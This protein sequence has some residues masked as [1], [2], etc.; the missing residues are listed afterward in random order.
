MKYL[1]EISDFAK[2]EIEENYTWWIANRSREQAD[3]WIVDIHRRISTI[4][5]DP[6]RYPVIRES[7]CFPFELREMLFSIGRRPT[8]RVVFRINGMVVE[9]F[10]VKHV[11]QEL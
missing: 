4:G 10:H 7:V 6:L 1:V 2:A 3:R 8:H 11:S 9:I 5:A